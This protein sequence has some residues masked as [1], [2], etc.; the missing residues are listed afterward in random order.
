[1]AFHWCEYFGGYTSSKCNTWTPSDVNTSATKSMSDF[2]IGETPIAEVTSSMLPITWQITS[3]LKLTLTNNSGNMVYTFYDANNNIIY[4]DDDWIGSDY[5]RYIIG[6]CVDDTRQQGAFMLGQYRRGSTSV[7]CYARPPISSMA[8]RLYSYFSEAE[9]PPVLYNWQS[10][11]SISGKNGILQSLSTLVNIND[12]NPVSGASASD[13]NIIPASVVSGMIQTGASDVIVSFEI[14]QLTSGTYDSIKLVG[15]RG[16]IPK[17]K[18]DG[19]SI[20]TLTDTD[21]SK[22]ITG[23]AQNVKYWF[24]IF[25]EDSKGGTSESEPYDFIIGDNPLPYVR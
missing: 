21:I 17:D 18:T 1:M 3:N 7:T 10:V 13:V 14:P 11:P 5:N 24:V 16:E 19:E 12:G 23:L 9:Q 2:T 22:T 8:E 6:F 25:T 4:Q 15:K 20:T